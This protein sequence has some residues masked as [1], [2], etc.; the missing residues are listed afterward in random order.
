MH[1]PTLEIELEADLPAAEVAEQATEPEPVSEP[2]PLEGEIRRWERITRDLPPPARN[3]LFYGSSTIRLWND[4][5]ALDFPGLPVVGRGFGG[6]DL[7]EAVLFF[8]RLVIPCRPSML[9]IYAG[10]NDLV[11]GRSVDDVVQSWREIVR[12]TRT[13]LG[14]IPV[15]FI[16]LKP[17]P[18]RLELREQVLEVNRRIK[19]MCAE[20][21]RLLHF[22]DICTPMLE[23][24]AA[25]NHGHFMNDQ[26]HLS[27][28]GYVLWASVLQKPVSDVYSY[29]IG[30]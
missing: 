20:S 29:A 21:P 3:I 28:E 27:R 9:V 1:M 6:S 23:A 14:S 2:H 10:E 11:H 5:L 22:V 16:S 30:A 4:K 25:G 12:R 17:S 18:A 7:D 8:D 26:L 13:H 15:V 24:Q 19:A